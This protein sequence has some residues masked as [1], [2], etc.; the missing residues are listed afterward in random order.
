MKRKI[1]HTV[2]CSG[3]LM[4]LASCE[5]DLPVYDYPDNMLN[6]EVTISQETKEPDLTSYSFVYLPEETVRDTVWVTVKTMGFLSEYDR[7]L[8][9]KQ[10]ASGSKDAEP[11]VHYVS[12]D[13]AEL[14]NKFYYIPAGEVVRKIPVVVLKDASLATESV[15]L[16]F[17]FKDNGHF[18]P[19]YP[20]YS[21]MR[22]NISNILTKPAAWDDYADYYFDKYGPVKHKFM[23][24]VTGLKWDNDFL[25]THLYGE[26]GYLAYLAQL[27]DKELRKENERRVEQGLPVLSEDDEGLDPVTFSYGAFYNG[28]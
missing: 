28:N 22:L 3:L 21:E 6:F 2:L 26:R 11:G 17:T 14:K 23:I 1:L 9:L 8:E 10:V 15:N 20:L 4:G 25:E 24:D 13:D 19:G 12:F 16:Y 7:P 18:R 27:C 5:K